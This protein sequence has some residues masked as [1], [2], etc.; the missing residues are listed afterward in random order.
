MLKAV[1][2][3]NPSL[4][5]SD[6]LTNV[7]NKCEKVQRRKSLFY[8]SVDFIMQLA[9]NAYLSLYCLRCYMEGINE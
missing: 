5:Q 4:E 6:L 1:S 9:S 7:V 8:I 2:A 3:L